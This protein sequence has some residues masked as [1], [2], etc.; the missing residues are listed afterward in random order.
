MPIRTFLA[1]AFLALLLVFAQQQAMLHELQH[2]TDA[3]AG[4]SLPG[5][6]HDTCLKCLSFADTGHATPT[7]VHAFEPG[8]CAQSLVDRAMPAAAPAQAFGA[9]DSRAPPLNA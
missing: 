9:Y 5:T 7:S 8:D 2:Q 6:H 4:K 1:R 3:V